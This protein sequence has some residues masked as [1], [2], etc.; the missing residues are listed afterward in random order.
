[1]RHALSAFFLL[2]GLP[3]SDQAPPIQ[4]HLS[5]EA[6][7][8]TL[9]QHLE[10]DVTIERDRFP[11]IVPRLLLPGPVPRR[12]PSWIQFLIRRGGEERNLAIAPEANSGRYDVASLYTSDLMFL[13]PR[14]IYGWRYDLNGADWLL[15]CSQGTYELQAR[16]N[17]KL[18]DPRADGKPDPAVR[19][20]LAR[21]SKTIAS[22]IIMNGSW[23]SNRIKLEVKKGAP[24]PP[25][26]L[27]PQGHERRPLV[28]FPGSH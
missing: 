2:L 3:A 9:G 28:R 26:C 6:Q 13:G 24:I 14:Q 1:M 7:E 8:L 19:A 18:L 16:L 17:V 10:C 20:I 25:R 27:G 5:C 23:F 12:P 15:P 22:K 21:Y 11:L 4:F